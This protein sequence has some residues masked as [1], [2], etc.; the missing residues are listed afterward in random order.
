[1]TPAQLEALGKIRGAASR[2][3]VQAD[4]AMRRKDPRDV[5]YH[6]DGVAAYA[7]T[8]QCCGPEPCGFF[9]DN[10]YPARWC[11]ASACMAWRATDNESGP[12]DP[13]RDRPPPSKPAG[14]CG[15]AGARQ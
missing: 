2:V 4:L 3:S 5:A 14:F 6:I 11:V 8:K 9:N 1:M 15:L 12:V 7:R 10:P 13:T